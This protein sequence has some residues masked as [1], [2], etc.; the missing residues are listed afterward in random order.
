MQSVMNEAEL[1]EYRDTAHATGPTCARVAERAR[2]VSDEIDE[3][4][5][6]VGT[7]VKPLGTTFR[8]W[9]N[10]GVLTW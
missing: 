8:V 5:E 3:K 1:I 6:R 4:L 9:N 7:F 10:V 2:D